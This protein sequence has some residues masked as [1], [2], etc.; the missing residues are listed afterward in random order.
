LA[1]G[2][3]ILVRLS[4]LNDCG[5]TY[6]NAL[7]RV[8]QEPSG[9]TVDFSFKGSS[10][11]DSYVAAGP[12]TTT[13]TG[14]GTPVSQSDGLLSWGGTQASPCWVGASFTN[15]S[16]TNTGFYGGLTSWTMEISHESFPGSNSFLPDGSYTETNP[17]NA[18]L[19]INQAEMAVNGGSFGANYFINNFN[20]TNTGVLGKLFKVKLSGIGVCG[21][22]PFKEGFFKIIPTNVSLLVGPD[23]PNGVITNAESSATL[24]VAPNPVKGELTVSLLSDEDGEATLRITDLNGRVVQLGGASD[25]QL[26][27]GLN[28]F[29]LD[30]ATLPPGVYFAQVIRSGKN[31]TARLVKI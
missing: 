6:T 17:A 29:T 1:D 4:V 18:Q 2:Q 8:F 19:Y 11:A 26:V 10:G 27:K 14:E 28:S 23:N 12:N 13:G 31:L 15:L 25:I 9:A 16:C 3:Y 30:L 20:S 21:Q 5:V 24:Q 22:L 7:V